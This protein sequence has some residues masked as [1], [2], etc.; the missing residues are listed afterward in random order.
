MMST[1]P[2]D[3]IGDPNATTILPP[4]IKTED[5]ADEDID[6]NIVESVPDEVTYVKYIPPPPEVPVLPPIHPRER[7]KQKIAESADIDIGDDAETI[8]YAPDIDDIP[9]VE[10][11]SNAETIS[12]LP[13]LNL[14]NQTYRKRAKK[15][16]LRH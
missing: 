4:L 8:T 7:L 15:K 2:D 3:I 14:R 11:D 12:Y 13:N 9:D 16:R 1:D 6:F 10:V 5:V